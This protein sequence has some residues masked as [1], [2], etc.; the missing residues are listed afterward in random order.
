M[1]VHT[2]YL[3]LGAMGRRL[4]VNA[5]LAGHPV[6]VWNR[7][8][9]AVEQLVA[10]HPDMR[11]ADSAA[12]AVRDAELVVV[13]VADDDASRE[14][15]LDRD[16][17]ATM[18]PGA[19]AVDASPLSPAWAVELNATATNAAVDLLIAPVLGSTPQA[20]AASLVQLVGGNSAALARVQ[21]VLSTS[22][23]TVLHVAGPA[24]AANRKL[25]VNGWLAGQAAIA[26]ELVA[27]LM[28][29]GM[30]EANASAFL[31]GL[32]LTS[33]P[34]R[35][36]IERAALGDVS[37]RFPIGLVAKDVRYLDGAV[38]GRPL[39]SAIRQAWETAA[40]VA[41]TEDLAGYRRTI[42]TPEAA[43]GVS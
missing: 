34:L 12:D 14:V 5:T 26:G 40:A 21:E 36:I 29:T 16:V 17:L 39:L 33:A 43:H 11:P 20:E 6:S 7:S 15:W 41:A 18:R 27:H 31:A 35:G 13:M 23:S 22:A 24:E 8:Q 19:V 25:V 10:D 30:P 9:T 28:R 37:P 4:A 1:T 32:P 2:A 42:P 38:G 3:G